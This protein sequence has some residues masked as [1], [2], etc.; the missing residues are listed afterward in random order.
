MP[1]EEDKRENFE[2]MEFIDLKYLP[3]YADELD[4]KLD[5]VKDKYISVS[6]KDCEFATPANLMNYLVN[7]NIKGGKILFDEYDEDHEKVLLE[8]MALNRNL[9]IY[10]LDE[11]IM[12]IV[13]ETDKA[14]IVD[15]K[16]KKFI[17]DFRTKYPNIIEEI[18]QIMYG[19][20][21]FCLYQI[22][23]DSKLLEE[24]N[25][26][27]T[28]TTPKYVGANIVN[29][30]SATMITLYLANKIGEMN[31]P[32]KRYQM[33]T[34]PFVSEMSC[35]DYFLET[36]LPYK[37]MYTYNETIRRKDKSSD[38]CKDL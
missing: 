23:K 36:F 5:E 38:V 1:Q 31:I 34:V 21:K 13:F 16:Y 22:S 32:Y 26:V 14:A 33:Y 18:D 24:M 35:M 2:I 20:N 15:K 37:I 19:I 12:S 17:E 10:N 28:I 6:Y 4:E 25:A 8:Y 9:D 7:C 3:F 27:K 29:I 11:E 30:K